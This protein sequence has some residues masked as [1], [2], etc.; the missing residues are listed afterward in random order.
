MSTFRTAKLAVL[1]AACAAASGIPSHSASACGPDSYTGMVCMTAATFCPRGYAEANGQLLAISS[2]TAL[3]SLIGTNYGG[4]GRTTFGLPDLRGR[5]PVGLGRGA[6][7]SNVIQ[8][9]RRGFEDVVQTVAMLAS[10]SHAATVTIPSSATLPGT[11]SV[12]VVP[13]AA[14]TGS[15]TASPAASTTYHLGGVGGRASD[16]PYS[17]GTPG[18][19]AAKVD[20]VSVQVDASALGTGAQVTVGNTGG[21]QPI[22]TVP[23]QLGMRFCISTNGIFPPR[24]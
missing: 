5:T 16:G 7:L 14:Q 2:N 24:S 18:G 6:G 23:P 19:N 9:E 4:D 12:S 21:S 15:G 10:H 13:G 1:A 3:F 11:G 20:G 22:P 8:G 17:S